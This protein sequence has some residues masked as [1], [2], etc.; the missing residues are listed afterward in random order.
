MNT[1]Q[2]QS[3]ANERGASVIQTAVA[4]MKERRIGWSKALEEARQQ[5]K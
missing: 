3:A 2:Q 1:P 4:L 5:V